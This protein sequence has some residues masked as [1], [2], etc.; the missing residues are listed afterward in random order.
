MKIWR[1]L[2]L[3]VV[4]MSLLCGLLAFAA[5][6]FLVARVIRD[7]ALDRFN[8]FVVVSYRKHE[9]PRCEAEP[10]RWRLDLGDGGR[11][12]TYDP[13]TL[14]SKNPEAPPLQREAFEALAP[15]AVATVV[16]LGI[17]RGILVLFRP[18][19]R[20]PCA[21]LAAYWPP[22]TRVQTRLISAPLLTSFGVAWLVIGLGFVVVI[23]PL[24]RRVERLR[25]A[26]E[27]LGEEGAYE[28]A[29]KSV[30]DEIGQLSARLDEAHERIRDDAERLRSR[31]SALERHLADIAHDLRTP[32]A[33]L[34]LAI[35]QAAD[36]ATDPEL[37]GLLAGA[38]KD[39][40]Y[41]AGLTDNLRIATQLREGWDPALSDAGVDLADTIERIASRARSF[42]RRRGIELEVSVPDAPVLARCD[43]VAAEQAFGNVV[44]NAITYGDAGGHVAVLLETSEGTFTVRVIDDGPGVAPTEI[45]RLTERT[46][47]S[48]VARQRD[49]RGSGLGLAITS[50]VCARC[51]WELS[52]TQESPRGL[53]VRISGP[54]EK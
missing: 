46:F 22:D 53:N 2:S 9:R 6:Q 14:L 11:G 36:L 21:L 43:A 23:R 47:R 4:I 12:Y 32:I 8:D 16:P 54:L 34:H 29:E 25:R 51:G 15:N 1:G 3:R 28:P 35:E 26:A 20:G 5:S 40:V 39:S 18:S 42:A 33:S 30:D 38:L 17:T 52:F 31:H 27:R 49:P 10:E 19:G 37:A 44:Q 50:E 13:D 41:L 45:P 24:A 7:T 48:D